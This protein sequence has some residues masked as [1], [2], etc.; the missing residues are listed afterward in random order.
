MIEVICNR[1]EEEM[2]SPGALVFSPPDREG[3]CLKIHICR[4]CWGHVLFVASGDDMMDP[5]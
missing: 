4:V 2:D 3:G 5:S 1:C